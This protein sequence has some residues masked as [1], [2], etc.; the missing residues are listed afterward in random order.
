ML[1]LPSYRRI[2]LPSKCHN[3]TLPPYRRIISTSQNSTLQHL[4]FNQIV[5]RLS[6][7]P[8]SKTS[9]FNRHNKVSERSNLIN[10]HN[11]SQRS[12]LFSPHNSKYSN[13][14]QLRSERQCRP[15]SRSMALRA[16][17]SSRSS[18]TA[19]SHLNCPSNFLFTRFT[20]LTR[21]HSNSAF[22]SLQKTSTIMS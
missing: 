2:I 8:L 17:N 12:N 1:L 20:S 22:K 21:S 4:T 16:S 9:V 11:S 15:A 6:S 19:A 3:S 10:P 18:P 13:R 5:L 14:S 7:S